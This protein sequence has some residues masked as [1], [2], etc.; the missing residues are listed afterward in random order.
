MV[1]TFKKT[2]LINI[3]IQR[4]TGILICHRFNGDIYVTL[5]VMLG[6][7]FLPMT[8]L[9]LLESPA[10]VGVPPLPPPPPGVMVV[11]VKLTL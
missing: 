8:S 3:G 1:N 10:L 2:L 7:V 4:I 5:L 6:P 9:M 11:G